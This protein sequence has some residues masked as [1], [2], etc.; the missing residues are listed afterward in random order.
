MSDVKAK[1]HQIFCQLGLR[2]RPRWGRGSAPPP[3]EPLRSLQRASPDPPSWI[4]GGLLTS[5]GGVEGTRREG[6]GG[7]R[8][9]RKKGRGGGRFSLQAKAWP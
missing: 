9:L 4:L 8:K 3:Q 5:I 2:H 7:E 1:M 6:R